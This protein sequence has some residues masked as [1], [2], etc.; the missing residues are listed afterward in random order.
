MITRH[1]ASAALMLAASSV[2]VSVPSLA[3]VA[4]EGCTLSI[5]M[6]KPLQDAAGYVWFSATFSICDDT[7]VRIKLRDLDQVPSV[8]AAECPLTQPAPPP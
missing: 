5:T 1:L 7:R 4:A 2:A 8:W 3:A 6:G